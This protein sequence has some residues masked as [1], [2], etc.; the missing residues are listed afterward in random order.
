MN[1]SPPPPSFLLLNNAEQF[2]ET[3]LT[4]IRNKTVRQMS[5]EGSGC[6]V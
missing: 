4:T 2:C 3:N 1:S 6:K 5:L